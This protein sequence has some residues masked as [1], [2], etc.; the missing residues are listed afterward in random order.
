M[1]YNVDAEDK[2]WWR[3]DKDFGPCAIARI[4][5]TTTG[6]GRQR[7]SHPTAAR[8]ATAASAAEKERG[9]KKERGRNR[10]TGKFTKNNP[11]S[12]KKTNDDAKG[13]AGAE[14][15]DRT[16]DHGS[17]AENASIDATPPPSAPAPSHDE[18]TWTVERVLLHNPKNLHSRHSTAQLVR[19]YNPKL[20]L[21]SFERM[22]G[23][24]EKITGFESIVTIARGRGYSCEKDA[25]IGRRV[26]T[27][28]GEGAEV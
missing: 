23:A 7:Q 12:A 16:N 6:N 10:K 18:P 15:I 4:A 19:R 5:T 14:F 8:S 24:L 28:V 17:N 26:R 27:A 25:G 9:A 13:D 22:I 21:K 11:P 2:A 3:E 1:E 20:S